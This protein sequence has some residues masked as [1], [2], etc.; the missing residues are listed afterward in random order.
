MKKIFAS[1][2]YIAISSMIIIFL[3]VSLFIYFN[4]T[5]K[6]TKNIT[7]SPNNLV[8][9]NEK[10][11][12]SENIAVMYSG[13]TDIHYGIPELLDA[14]ALIKKENYELWI[15]GTGNAVPLIKDRA[16]DG[17]SG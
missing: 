10:V 3:I 5:E 7:K 11:E 1:K 12:K 15:T 6:T 9:K 13:V 4:N 8:S 17:L 14:F 2:K 16:G